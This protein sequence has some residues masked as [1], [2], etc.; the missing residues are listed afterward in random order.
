MKKSILF[1]LTLI[2]A[3]L[4]WMPNARTASD[5]EAEIRQLLDRW[6]KAFRSKDLNGVMAIYEPG[7]AL[8]AY[9]I[10]P[11]LQY[12]GYDAYKN[13][14]EGAGLVLTYKTSGIFNFAHG[15]IAALAAFVFYFLRQLLS[16]RNLLFERVEIHFPADIPATDLVGVFFRVIAAEPV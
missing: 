4:L 5:S 7:Q 3:S 14:L 6:A 10:V 9:D 15:S 8:V 13:A 1:S 12:T 11:P 2:C 16:Q